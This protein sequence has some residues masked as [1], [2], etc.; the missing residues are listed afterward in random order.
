MAE[1]LTPVAVSSQRDRFTTTSSDD[2]KPVATPV[3]TPAKADLK[4]VA[5]LGRGDLKKVAPWR[6]RIGGTLDRALSLAHRNQKDLW[7]ALGHSNGAQV[8]RWIAG[9]ERMQLDALLAVDWLRQP[10]ALAIAELADGVVITT[11][12]TFEARR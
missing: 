8:N 4:K 11:S 7:V 6:A 1:I 12:I 5:E 3:A 10:L 2:R 9:T